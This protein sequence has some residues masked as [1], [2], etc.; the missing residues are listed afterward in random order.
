MQSFYFQLSFGETPVH[1]THRF[2]GEGG[3]YL[4]K[5]FLS[6]VL[7]GT[8]LFVMGSVLAPGHTVFAQEEDGYYELDYEVLNADNDS[9]SVA[10]DYFEKPAVLI[11]ENGEKQI[12]LSINHSQWVVGLEAPQGDDFV[13]VEVVGEDEADDVRIVQFGVEDEEDFAEPLELKMHIVVD[14]LDEPYDHHYTARFAFDADSMEEVDAPL[15][16]ME[17]DAE[18]PEEKEEEAVPADETEVS[19][20]EDE[21]PTDNPTGTLIVLILL[22]SIVVILLYSFVFKKKK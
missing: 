9:V 18:A 7:S 11:L 15:Q 13:D 4:Y 21:V 8:M 16:T 17:E 14:T 1:I 20:S 12:Q 5:R 6:M 2:W 22:A 3:T 10:N 19:D